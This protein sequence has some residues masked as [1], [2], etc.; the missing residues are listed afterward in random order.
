MRSVSSHLFTCSL[1]IAFGVAR[2]ERRA[3]EQ[4][5]VFAHHAAEHR[6]RGHRDR[7]R[8]PRDLSER[9]SPKSLT[10]WTQREAARPAA[11]RP[12]F[13]S[14]TSTPASP[15]RIPPTGRSA[16]AW[17]SGSRTTPCSSAGTARSARSTT[18]PRRSGTI[19]ASSSGCVLIFRDVTSSARSRAR[20]RPALPTRPAARVDRRV[21]G[22]RHRRQVARRHRAELECRRPSASSATRAAEAIGRHISL[23]IPPERLAEEDEIIAQLEGRARVEHFETERLRPRRQPV[24]GLADGLADPRR[25]GHVIGAS[26]IVRDA[27]ASGKIEQRERQLL[28]EAAAANAESRCS[29][30]RATSSPAS[31]M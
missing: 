9:R 17:S 19:A 20:S 10:G 23:I 2:A 29:S 18:A 5:E 27:A 30:I 3:A 1:I 24:S 13:A 25:R 8:R 6:R 4:R 31:W 14:S 11:R 12:C 22:R 7:R 26:K 28:V 21:L 15:S 16:R